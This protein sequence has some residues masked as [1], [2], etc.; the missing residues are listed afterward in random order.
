MALT[1]AN[2]ITEARDHL[3]EATAVFWSDAQLTKW[4]QEGTRVVS[5]KALAVEADDSIT[6]IANQLLYTSADGAGYT[7][8]ADCIEPYAAYY[9]DGSNGYK[10]IIKVHPREI[11]NVA[12]FTSG[13]PKYYCIHNRSIYIWPLTTA[14]IVTAGGTVMVLYS[15][16]TDDIT[17]LKDEY[18]H[19]AIN[20]AVAKAKFRDR[21]FGEAA[22]IINQVYQELNFERKDKHAREVDEL[23]MFNVKG[24]RGDNQVGRR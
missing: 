4:I 15:K 16:E 23:S 7:W 9:D 21:A 8:I 13:D 11:G 17:E 18:Q 19:L 22:S 20:Y 24:S 2:A 12:T 10:G 14:A 1:L 3:N 5:S 6:L